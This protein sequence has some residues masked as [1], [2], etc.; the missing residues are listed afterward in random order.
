MKRFLFRVT[1]S[2]AIAGAG[3]AP[4]GQRDEAYQPYAGDYARVDFGE[5]V[6]SI[7]PQRADGGYENLHVKLDILL[8]PKRA[9]ASAATATGLV[10]RLEAR[11]KAEALQAVLA[12]GPVSVSTLGRLREGIAR[13]VQV[14]LDNQ[15]G[16]WKNAGDFEV[17]VVVTSLY[18][19]GP[20]TPVVQGQRWPF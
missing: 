19:T 16:K 10:R 9:L 12:S 11:I 2:T 7:P 1:L 13:Q 20:D 3:C 6:V 18:L 8:N 15:F 5:V 17:E 4:F 14:A